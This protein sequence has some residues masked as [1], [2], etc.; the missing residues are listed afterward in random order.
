MRLER[1]KCRTGGRSPRRTAERNAGGPGEDR[2]LMRVWRHMLQAGG[3][4]VL[5][6]PSRLPR[7]ERGVWGRAPR[8][9]NP[10]HANSGDSFSEGFVFS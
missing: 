7:G 9:S 3:W 2:R 8:C 10:P 6:P 1:V 4:G 5:F